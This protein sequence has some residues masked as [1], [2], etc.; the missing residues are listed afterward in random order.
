[1]GVGELTNEMWERVMGIDLNGPM[2]CS[3][4]AIP[5]MPGRAVA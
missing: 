3:R 5:I 4:R 2:F 1:M